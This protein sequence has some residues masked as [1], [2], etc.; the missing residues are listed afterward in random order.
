MSAL[1]RLH[2]KLCALTLSTVLSEARVVN[3]T[4]TTILT[5]PPPE[6]RISDN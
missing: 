3:V 2:L 4:G 6:E 1:C 5:T